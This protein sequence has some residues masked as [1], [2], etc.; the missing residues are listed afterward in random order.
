MFLGRKITSK[1][2]FVCPSSARPSVRRQMERSDACKGLKMV[3][4]L[5]IA[6]EVLH[7]LLSLHLQPWDTL[8][9]G[10]LAQKNA[11]SSNFFGIVKKIYSG[12]L[13][14]GFFANIPPKISGVFWVLDSGLWQRRRRGGG[15]WSSLS[16]KAWV[17]KLLRLSRLRAMV[18]RR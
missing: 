5:P 10:Y 17:G 9:T 1:N 13:E 16:P 14:D 4:H 7:L 12:K 2:Q 8:V 11:E 6:P 15:I 3:L 18:D